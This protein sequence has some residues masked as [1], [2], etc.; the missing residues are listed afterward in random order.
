[1]TLTQLRT[2]LAIADTGSIYAAAERLV[3]SQS[4][5]S[6][7][8]IA[9]QK[10]IG[11]RLLERDGRGV[12]L[13]RA[14]EVYAHYVRGILGML[15]QARFAAT[16]ET[17]PE[18]GELRI[19]ALTTPGEQVLPSL[20]ASFRTHHPHVDMQVEV[21]NRDQVYP[22]LERHE[23]ELVLGGSPPPDRDLVVLAI[24]PY[25][26]IVV[27]PSELVPGIDEDVRAWLAR[28]TWL[29]RERGSGTRT[30]TEWFV[31]GLD[32][33]GPR[34]VLTVGSNS[35]IRESVASGLGV[36]LMSRDAVARELLDGRIVEVPAPGTPLLRDW[37]LLANPGRLSATATMLASHVLE[38]G[39]FQPAKAVSRS[40]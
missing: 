23:V 15:E 30:V 18:R 13:T 10:S 5:A 40:S 9:L 27:S 24:R 12:R 20:L 2:F 35:A 36:T 14:G 39:Q 4:A 28:Q 32:L 25:E 11:L 8:L 26:L 37:H 29:L 3:V 34:R 19:A 22:L 33:G 6:A 21:G 31:R 1:M 16:A 38:T 17:D 7:S